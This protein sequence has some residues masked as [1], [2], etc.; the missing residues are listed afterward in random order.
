MKLSAEM[1][2]DVLLCIEKKCESFT[3]ENGAFYD[4]DVSWK[5]IY[6]D[7]YLSKTYIDDE[8]KYCLIRL[9][10]HELI[11]ANS[12]KKAGGID[13][14]WINNLTFEGHELLEN[15][16]DDEVWKTIKS[17]LGNL[18]NC[19]IK[20]LCQVAPEIIKYLINKK[21]GLL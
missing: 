17:K 3:D 6:E 1:I 7:E 18:S 9:H 14:L 4:D 8:I 15:I 11:S 20:I 10:E 16:R 5:Y 21:L 2:R 13:C 12:I 19:S